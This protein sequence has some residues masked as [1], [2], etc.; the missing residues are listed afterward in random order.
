MTTFFPRGNLT[1]LLVGMKPERSKCALKLLG[2]KLIIPVETA[3]PVAG[4]FEY[5]V[6]IFLYPTQEWELK[7]CLCFPKFLVQVKIHLF[8]GFK[9]LCFDFNLFYFKKYGSSHFKAKNHLKMKIKIFNL[10]KMS[11]HYIIFSHFFSKMNLSEQML[12]RGSS[13]S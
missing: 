7:S 1:P 12:F 3:L 2:G 6:K 5:S 9:R 13:D 11:K 10:G 4:H 8:D